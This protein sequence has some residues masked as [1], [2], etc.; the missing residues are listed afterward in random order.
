MTFIERKHAI[1]TCQ[2]M[3]EFH[4][5]LTDLYLDYGMNLESNRGRRNILMSAPM[6][7]FLAEE[8]R[9]TY[10]DVENDGRTGKADIV[11]KLLQNDHEIECKLTSPHSSGTIAFQS[12]YETLE[13]KGPLDY[14][15]IIANEDFD[16][17]VVIYFKG[18]TVSDFRNLSSGARGKVQ[19]YKYRGMEKA[20]VLVGD[21]INLK[22]RAIKKL[23]DQILDIRKK[24]YAQVKLWEGVLLDT[25]LS[26]PAKIKKY[27][28]QI[29]TLRENSH[30]RT[31]KIK[32]KI[33]SY[34]GKHPRY[35]LQY[36]EI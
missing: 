33:N 3:K 13:K 22:E 12:D 18:L 7:H 31:D 36:E 26:Q 29:D 11:I 2:R 9:K 15:Y 28:D 19:M 34:N 23:Q 21:V 17:F 4:L 30:K 8:L 10:I 27:Q 6:E 5:K 20:E 35:K 25:K 14:I 1:K 16:G 24:T 32:E